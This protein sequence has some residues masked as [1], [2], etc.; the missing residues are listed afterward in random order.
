[1]V[2]LYTLIGAA[3]SPTIYPNR[4]A[5]TL[6]AYFLGLGLS[7]H[8]LNE[9][10]ANHWTEAL[11][12]R[13]LT[14]L[15]A[16]PLVA[17]IGIGIYAMVDLYALSNSIIPPVALMGFIILETFFLFAYN[18]DS[19]GGIF[20]SDLSFAFSWAALPTV[21]GYYVNALTITSVAVL[22]A[23]GMA[24][25]A[26]VEINLSRWCKDFRRKSPLTNMRFLDGT[27][28]TMNTVQLLSRPERSLKLIVIAVDLIAIGLI[29]YRLFP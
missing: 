25:T 8:A 4:V 26:G 9:L 3:L 19:F 14:V 21:I 17:A 11:G 12:K 5:L 18:T 29:V 22:V 13:E 27:Q 16:L 7:A 24:A 20:D 6:V 10:H 15:F 28:Q 23:L 1:M 2:L